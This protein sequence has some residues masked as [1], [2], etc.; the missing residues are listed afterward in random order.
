[1]I[2][3]MKTLTESLCG[4]FMTIHTQLW[5]DK[6]GHNDD[7]ISRLHYYQYPGYVRKHQEDIIPSLF[8]PHR[9]T[10]WNTVA[11]YMELA[12]GSHWTSCVQGCTHFNT[13]KQIQGIIH[14]AQCFILACNG[15]GNCKSLANTGKCPQN[16]SHCRQP[17]SLSMKT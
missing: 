12:R 11:N 8:A 5:S 17:M 10:G 15:Q 9:L 14:Q 13:S 6:S 16:K 4:S 2:W 7:S 3:N 1:M